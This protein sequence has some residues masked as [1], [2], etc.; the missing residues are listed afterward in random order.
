MKSKGANLT[1]FEK[2]PPQVAYEQAM[3]QWQQ[4]A[5]EIAKAGQQ[6]PPQPTPEQFGYQ[7]AGVGATQAATPPPQA[8]VT[9]TTQ[10]ITRNVSNQNAS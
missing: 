5:V 3:Q 8:Q 4:V 6:P 7:P 2:S 10:N 1:P 9:N